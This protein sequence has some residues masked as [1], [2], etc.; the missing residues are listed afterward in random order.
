MKKILYPLTCTILVIAACG[1][2]NIAPT[3]DPNGLQTVIVSTA[4]AAQNQTQTAT[5]PTGTPIPTSIL[6]PTAQP[7]WPPLPTGQAPIWADDRFAHSFIE[8]AQILPACK[9]VPILENP[10]GLRESLHVLRHSPDARLLPKS[11]RR[12]GSRAS[13]RF[14]SRRRQRVGPLRGSTWD[15]GGE[16][17]RH[18]SQPT[19]PRFPGLWP[20]S[21]AKFSRG[22]RCP[23]CGS[24][25][26]NRWTGT[27]N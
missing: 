18:L 8:A 10:G 23:G 24:A 6:Y 9:P 13:G 1:T 15:D 20:A 25:P 12:N 2:S 21:R 26:S 11:P 5:I 19:E 27:R 17:C 4:L 22:R 7:T 16:I 3:L 14:C